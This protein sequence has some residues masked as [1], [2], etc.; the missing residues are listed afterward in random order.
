MAIGKRPVQQNTI[1]WSNRNR[2]NKARANTNKKAK[3]Q[4][5]IPSIILWM[6][7]TVSFTINSGMFQPPIN[8]I[9]ESVDISTI[10]EYSPK[11][12]KTKI[13]LEC[14]V[15]KPATNSDSLNR[16]NVTY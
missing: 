13:T 12:K 11:K 5:L 14:S 2:G 15:K 7:I 10:E 4:V 3:K 6:F 16:I 9:A 8:K 1:N